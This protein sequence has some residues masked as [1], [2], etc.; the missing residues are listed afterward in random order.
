M[1][2]YSNIALSFISEREQQIKNSP[3]IMG[4]NCFIIVDNNNAMRM[5]ASTTILD[6]TDSIFRFIII[7]IRSPNNRGFYDYSTIETYSIDKNGDI[8]FGITIDNW[9]IYIAPQDLRAHT[10]DYPEFY[11]Y[12]QKQ[13]DYASSLSHLWQT[14]LK[15]KECKGLDM[16]MA[17]KNL[18]A[19][20]NDKAHLIK[21]LAD[22]DVENTILKQKIRDYE[23]LL[24]KM[25]EI[26]NRS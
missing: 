22:K 9:E 6:E 2:K 21:E 17:F 5:S 8:H 15:L 10:P 25:K 12:F 23:I 7:E 1:E 4:K 26:I 18:Y 14:F 11:F 20:T 19:I 3:K 16:L 13:N 24:D